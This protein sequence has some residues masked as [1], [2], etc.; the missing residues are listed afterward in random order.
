VPSSVG[1]L[2]RTQAQRLNLVG[3]KYN[4][5]SIVVANRGAFEKRRVILEPLVI[6]TEALMMIFSSFVMVLVAF[7]TQLWSI[8][9][10]A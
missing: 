6:G 4:C 5:R 7:A 8:I 9:L 1:S 2:Q 3:S 10:A